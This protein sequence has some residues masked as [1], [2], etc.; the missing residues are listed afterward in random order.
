MKTDEM[1][2]WVSTVYLL[3]ILIVFTYVS[4]RSGKCTAIRALLRVTAAR[5]PASA[6]TAVIVASFLICGNKVSVAMERVQAR[7]SVTI[8]N[9]YDNSCV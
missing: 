9:L 1:M 6:W 5:S 4:S 8:T 3:F 2:G 7:E